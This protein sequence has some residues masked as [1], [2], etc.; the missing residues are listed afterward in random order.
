VW[1]WLVLAVPAGLLAGW[2][3]DRPVC[4]ELR[5]ISPR[6]D[7]GDEMT[8]TL[9]EET[10]KNGADMTIVGIHVGINHCPI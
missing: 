9:A 5:S 7:R 6:N 4:Y 3:G 10:S 1:S 8:A 2:S